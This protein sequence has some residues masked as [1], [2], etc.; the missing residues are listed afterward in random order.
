MARIAAAAAGA[1]VMAAAVLAGITWY[2]HSAVQAPLIQAV[3]HVGGLSGTQ[4]TAGGAGVTVSLKPGARL[5][6]VYP[7]VEAAARAAAGHSVPVA[8]ADHPT[9]AERALMAQM[10]FVVATGEATGQYVAMQQALEAQAKQAHLQLAVAL[11]GAHLYLTITD[12]HA[13]RLMQVVALPKGGAV[14]A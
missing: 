11:G 14:R 7:A 10:Q 4:L 2:H 5:A 6:E 12:A 1:A 8:L 13:H 3:S 9:A